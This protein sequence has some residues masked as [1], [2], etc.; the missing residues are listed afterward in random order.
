MSIGPRRKVQIEQRRRKVVALMLKGRS[1]AEIAEHLS[2]TQPTVS[3]DLKRIRAAWREATV[4]DFEAALTEQL[5][6]LTLIRHEA[7][8]GWE[9][10]KQ[11]GHTA[12]IQAAGEGEQAKTR[13]TIKHQNGDPRFLEQV[14]K[15]LA[16]ARALLGLGAAGPRGDASP[17]DPSP[18][19]LSHILQAIGD[20]PAPYSNV[21]AGAEE[22]ERLMQEFMRERELEQQ[23]REGERSG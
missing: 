20:R 14:Q 5:E 22:Y 1:Q 17:A 13:Q 11:P 21:V 4:R 8:E 7:W 6:M 3:N 9:R 15:C 12:V 19:N 10:S 16:S 18:F 2:V 23:Q